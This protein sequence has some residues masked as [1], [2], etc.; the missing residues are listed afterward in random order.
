ML[1]TLSVAGV[2]T[3]AMIAPVIPFINDHEIEDLVAAAAE[4]GARHMAYILLRLPLEVA[5]LFEAWLEAHYPLKAAGA[6][7]RHGVEQGKFPRLR[8]DLFQ[9][10]GRAQMPLF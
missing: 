4:A 5:G 2:P 3:G 9:P 1:K 7:R 10:K 8:T 6:L